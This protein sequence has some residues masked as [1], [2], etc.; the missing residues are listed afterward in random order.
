MS[1]HYYSLMNTS[2]LRTHQSTNRLDNTLKK[3]EL[4]M[5]DHKFS[6]EDNILVFDFLNRVVDEANT[7]GMNGGKLIA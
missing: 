6:S 7:L 5:R 1:Y 2:T 3:I 4:T